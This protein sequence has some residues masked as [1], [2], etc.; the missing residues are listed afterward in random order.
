MDKFIIFH[1]VCFYSLSLLL[2]FFFISFISCKKTYPIKNILPA[3]NAKVVSIFPK[4]IKGEKP[5]FSKL[6]LPNGWLGF[7]AVY[8]KDKY[9]IRILQSV[10]PAR[11]KVKLFFQEYV[12]KEYT[13]IQT[14]S[15][16]EKEETILCHDENDPQF[17]LFAWIN[18]NWIFIIRA[19]K[20][21]NVGSVI[22]EFL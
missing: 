13:T 22:K 18:T 2:I 11:V 8:G 7:Q 15:F 19:N 21:D 5:V 4:S 14:D 10:N 12:F 17:E 16:F 1:R 6:H 9:E 3:Q 20:Q